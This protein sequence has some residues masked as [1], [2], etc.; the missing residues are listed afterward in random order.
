MTW[1]NTYKML[2]NHFNN[3]AEDPPNAVSHIYSAFLVM[4]ELDSN[5]VE[6]VADLEIEIYNL[7]THSRYHYHVPDHILEVIKKINQ[8]T[9]NKYGNLTEFVNNISWDNG[10]V[11]YYWGQYSGDLGFDISEWNICS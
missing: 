2:A 8:F 10:C 4:I 11:P 1:D 5:Y 9:E 3:V 7:W 6:E